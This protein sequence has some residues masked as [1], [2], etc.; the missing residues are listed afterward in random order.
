MIFLLVPWGVLLFGGFVFGQPDDYRRMPLWTRLGSSAV[1]VM[2]AVLLAVANPSPFAWLIA[3]GMGL[4]FVGDLYMADCIPWPR[5]HVLGGMGSFGLGHIAYIGACLW[6]GRAYA[7]GQPAVQWGSWVGW[8]LVAALIWYWLIYR[9]T[10][11]R[12]ILIYAALPYAMLLA[13]TVGVG[14]G[15]ALDGAWDGGGD[16]RFLRFTLGAALFLFSDLLIA[17]DLFTKRRFPLMGD[18]IW[19]TYGPA[20]ALIV[21]SVL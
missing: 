13:S 21:Y 11:E 16:G 19:L 4:G 3:L 20:Q 6:Y 7:I 10:A 8:L 5:P 14:M 18:V 2:A 12:N 9:G 17:V 1:L 15:L